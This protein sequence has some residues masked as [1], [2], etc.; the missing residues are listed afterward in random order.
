MTRSVGSTCQLSFA[1]TVETGS[2]YP[3]TLTKALALT[4]DADT[5]ITSHGGLAKPKD[6][7]VHRDFM[8]DFLESVR[9]AKKAGRTAA[10][11]ARGLASAG[12]LRRLQSGSGLGRGRH[13]MDLPPAAVVAGDGTRVKP[14]ASAQFRSNNAQTPG[15][16]GHHQGPED[17]AR[18][19]DS[20]PCTVCKTSIPGSNPGGA[21]IFQAQIRSVCSFAAQSAVRRLSRI[22]HPLT[23]TRRRKSLTRCELPDGT[24]RRAEVFRTSSSSPQPVDL[25][26]SASRVLWPCQPDDGIRSG[27]GSVRTRR[28]LRR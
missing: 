13:R 8:R 25:E 26:R 15:T 11:A 10:E 14:I 18:H 28:R 27:W 20:Q 12:A 1:P 17:E 2:P 3:E 16:T 21:S 22:A 19:Y 7:E 23:V 4:R 9:Q 5:L 6:L 24:R